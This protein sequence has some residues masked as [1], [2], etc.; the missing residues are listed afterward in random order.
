MM[1]PKFTKPTEMKKGGKKKKSSSTPKPTNPSL[2]SRAK[3]QAK[4]K[5]DVYPSAYAN[6]WASK[7]YKSK[8]GGW[9]GGSKKKAEGGPISYEQGASEGDL[10]KIQNGGTHE[11]SPLG[12]VPI[13]KDADGREVLVEEGETIRKGPEED[14][15]FSDRLKLTKQEAEEFGID[16]KFVGQSFA[17]VSEKLEKRSPRKSDPIDKQTLDMHLN[18]LEEAQE[19]F[20]QRKFA[21]AKEMYGDPEAEMQQG[22]EGLPPDAM[23]GV[24]TETPPSPEQFAGSPPEVQ[25]MLAQRFPEQFGGGAPQGPPSGMPQG[26]PPGMPAGMPQG[27]APMMMKHG[28]R[29]YT[30]E[31]LMGSEVLPEGTPITPEIQ[32]F[33]NYI[34]TGEGRDRLDPNAFGKADSTRAHWLQTLAQ[35]ASPGDYRVMKG[36]SMPPAPM[37]E[38]PMMKPHGGP[39]NKSEYGYGDETNVPNYMP[40]SPTRN[41]APSFNPMPPFLQASQEQLDQSALE[42]NNVFKLN[43]FGYIPETD[44]SALDMSALEDAESRGAAAGNSQLNSVLEKML[45]DAPG[46]ES[47]EFD[48]DFANYPKNKNKEEKGKEYG[49]DSGGSGDSKNTKEFPEYETPKGLNALQAA[50]IASNLVTAAMLPEQFD[51][52]NYKL[53]KDDNILQKKDITPMIRD[54][55]RMVATGRGALQ[56]RAGSVSELL[57]GLSNLTAVGMAETGKIRNQQYADYTEALRNQQLFNLNIAKTNSEMKAAVDTANADL[58][59]ERL[60]LINSAATEASK[61]ADALRQ[62]SLSKYELEQLYAMYPYLQGLK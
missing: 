13:G 35:E 45:A 43:K 15:V 40:F 11:E 46:G 56:S 61:F 1:Y 58:E 60:S 49:A 59:K 48:Y 31:N 20:K 28:G 34:D 6:A 33:I 36:M 38:T 23:P 18:R 47:S 50:P 7:W 39:Y 8:G 62:E 55:E 52:N 19:T 22:P 37:S 4:S 16:K 24:G 25:A 51:F 44:N 41:T 5:F 57:A 42:S 10:M 12:G 3:A 54:V 27:A 21:E 17:T 29:H 30:A 26:M 53:P 14:F 9:R 32:N 2:W